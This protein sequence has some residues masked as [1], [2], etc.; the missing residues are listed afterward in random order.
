AMMVGRE[1]SDWL[2]PAKAA[3][4]I[5]AP[6]L[7]VRDFSR[8]GAFRGVSFAVR[9]GE[10][11][12]MAG[13]VGAGRSEVA[14]ALFGIDRAD[15]GAVRI[16]GHGLPLGSTPA[17]MRL[18]VALVP[19]D[20]QRQGLALPMSVRENLGLA[21]LRSLTRGGL[22]SRKKE[23]EL[24]GRVMADLTI[25]ASSP[26]APVESLS[27]GNQQ[28]VLLG[29]WLARRPRVLILDE[30]TRGIDVGAKA[31]A[32]RLI[33]QLAD[34]GV[35]ILL[36]SS[37][38]PE[39]LSMCDR[40]LVMREG[41][42]AGELTRE[43]ATQEKVLALA[44]PEG[45]SHAKFI[46]PASAGLG[47]RPPKGGTTNWLARLARQRE[48]G[49]LT[50]LVLTIATVATVNPAFLQ[51]GNIAD[52][53]VKCAPA[54]IV[55]C[56]LT[57]VIVTREIDISV[58]SLM[59][60]LAAV[61]GTLVSK[62][63]MGLP[64]PVGVALTLAM[65]TAVGLTTG[66]LSTVGRVPSI[67]VTLGMLTALRGATEL[68]MGGEWIT[69]LPAGLRYLGTGAW[70]GVPICVWT[71]ALAVAFTSC[72]IRFAPLVRR[73]YAVGSNPRSA[74]LAGLSPRRVRL[75][76][77]AFTGF[78]TAVATLVSVPQ[79]SVIESG[80]GVGFELLVVT[81]VVVGGT[82]IS[83]GKG[84]IAGSVLGVLLMGIIS[85]VLIFLR[86]GPMATYWERAI[87]GAFILLAV[88]MDHLAR[89]HSRSEEVG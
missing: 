16:E 75:F 22:L 59:G 77:F 57:L 11:V 88:L 64:T 10:I 51:A 83:G 62:Q 25:R 65:G 85:T 32:H 14:R 74:A 38:L 43:E 84:T 82:S 42:I 55:A 1:V 71:A 34:Q 66:F 45:A 41:E 21:V 72:L 13:L 5:G 52:M 48:Y 73:V 28:K 35:A 69:D 80:V 30:P 27:G 19:E 79:L 78:L 31:E 53:L 33:R 67:I 89:R 76:A 50:L 46:V 68:A 47:R 44:L 70:L 54:A 36:I 9:A 39:V 2:A 63:R 12:G 24:A 17:A 86:L 3:G 4:A 49:V 18:G 87:Q 23:N 56:G 7:D 60:L 37:E 81:C 61:V 26:A 6:V 29:K 40:I 8:N 15:A 20:R 58:G